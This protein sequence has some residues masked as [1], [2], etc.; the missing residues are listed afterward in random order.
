MPTRRD[1]EATRAAILEAAESVF[2]AKGTGST[3][4]AEIAERA[5]VTKSLIHHHFGSKEGL[6]DAVKR[7]RFSEYAEQQMAAL[8]RSS[9]T[10]ELLRQSMELYF[11]FLQRNPDVARLLAWMHLECDEGCMDLETQLTRAG[12]AK[13]TAAQEAGE[14]RGDLDPTFVL[15]AFLALCQFWAQQGSLLCAKAGLERPKSELDEAYLRDVVRI[16]FEGVLPR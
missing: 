14:L 12:V 1:P 11:R 4:T 2:L 10:A 7:L 8:E 9:S 15:F 3:T 13:I 5:G 6:W 16:F